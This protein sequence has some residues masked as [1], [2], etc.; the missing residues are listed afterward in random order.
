MTRRTITQETPYKIVAGVTPCASGWLLV[1]AKIKGATF[2][3]DFPRVID[4]LYDVFNRRPAYS[5][6]AMNAPIGSATEASSGGRKCDLEVSQLI[7]PGALTSRWPAEAP[8]NESPRPEPHSTAPYLDDRRRE[9]SQE[10]APYLQRVVCEVLPELTFYQL[11]GEQPL[12]EPPTTEA[13]YRERCELLLRVPGIGRILE[14]ELDGVTRSQLLDAS[15]LLWSARRIT[16]RAG[17]RVPSL[18]EWD[19]DGL[20]VEILR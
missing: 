7:G 10:I 13:G 15:A 2:A 8:T 14:T 9:L 17:R 11:N 20:R 1:S 4:R 12:R 6:I 3:P 18:P 19:D 16:A 5:I